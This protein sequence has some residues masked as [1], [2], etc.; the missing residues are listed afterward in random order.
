MHHLQSAYTVC[1]ALLEIVCTG[2]GLSPAWHKI[3]L[4]H[5]AH[6]FACCCRTSTSLTHN[7]FPSYVLRRFH[8]QLLTASQLLSFPL[9]NDMLKF[10]RCSTSLTS[11]RISVCITSVGYWRMVQISTISNHVIDKRNAGGASCL[12]YHIVRYPATRTRQQCPTSCIRIA[13]TSRSSAYRSAFRILLRSSSFIDSRNSSLRFSTLDNTGLFSHEGVEFTYSFGLSTNDP[14]AG[15]PTET[16]LRLLLPL[17]SE[18]NDACCTRLRSVRTI[19]TIHRITQSVG[20][21]GGVYKGQGRNQHKLM[22]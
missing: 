17:S 5:D 15:S 2:M 9:P 16:L 13:Q 11:D 21:T 18:V 20:A 19:V 6:V 3:S 14:S 8:S 22:T 10:S 12:R 4:A 7:Q 1:S